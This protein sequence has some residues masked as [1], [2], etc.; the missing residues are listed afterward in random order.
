MSLLVI[1][2]AITVNLLYFI[3]LANKIITESQQLWLKRSLTDGNTTKERSFCASPKNRE[4]L[5]EKLVKYQEMGKNHQVLEKNPFMER[6][7]RHP[8]CHPSSRYSPSGT[9]HALF[10]VC[11]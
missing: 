7:P 2:V 9:F 3:F 4:D 1:F 11:P 5:L 8:A 6:N 10:G